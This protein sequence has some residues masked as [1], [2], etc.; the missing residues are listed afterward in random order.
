MKQADIQAHFDEN[1]ARYLG[2]GAEVEAYGTGRLVAKK[3]FEKS[4]KKPHAGDAREKYRIG[5]EQLGDLAVPFQCVDDITIWARYRLLPVISRRVRCKEPVIQERIGK[6]DFLLPKLKSAVVRGQQ[7]EVRDMIESFFNTIMKIW[8]RGLVVDYNAC[9]FV[10]CEGMKTRTI[11]L[12]FLRDDIRLRAYKMEEMKQ[13]L[14]RNL[15][16]PNRKEAELLR[17]VWTWIDARYNDLLFSD[18]WLSANYG[19]DRERSEPVPDLD[20]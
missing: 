13:T 10:V 8:T 9:N 20:I 19:I 3:F 5:K 17:I 6:K 12:G 14:R 4:E 7:G 1:P 15:Y 16:T 2:V 18:T 11:D